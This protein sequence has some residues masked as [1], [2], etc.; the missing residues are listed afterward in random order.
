MAVVAA[1]L[2]RLAARRI[3]LLLVLQHRRRH[4]RVEI[5]IGGLLLLLLSAWLLLLLVVAVRWNQLRVAWLFDAACGGLFLLCVVLLLVWF[6][7]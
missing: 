7:R 3:H 5:I 6:G 4:Q 2:T 1:G